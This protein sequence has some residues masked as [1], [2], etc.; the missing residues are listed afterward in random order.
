VRD[1]DNKKIIMRQIDLFSDA[2]LNKQEPSNSDVGSISFTI[3]D[4]ECNSKIFGDC[5]ICGKPVVQVHHQIR[6]KDTINPI[7]GEKGKIQISD[8]YGHYQCLLSVR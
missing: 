2:E 3:R 8:A 6:W 7:T 1:F 4:T 5:E